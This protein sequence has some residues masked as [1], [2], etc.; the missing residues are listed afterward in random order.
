MSEKEAVE[1][2]V[3]SRMIRVP[4]DAE[5]IEV[6]SAFGG[7]GIYDVGLL[8]GCRYRPTAEDGSPVCEHVPMH[9]QIREKGGRLFIEPSLIN[10]T[11][12]QEHKAT[13]GRRAIAWL[14]GLLRG[15]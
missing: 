8:K 2:F 5:R 1:E 3:E 7:L 4:P 10:G 15:R 6:E 13:A 9:A 12:V 14:T 11:G